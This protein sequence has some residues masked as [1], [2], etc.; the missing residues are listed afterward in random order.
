MEAVGPQVRHYGDPR[1]IATARWVALFYCITIHDGIAATGAR[2]AALSELSEALVNLGREGEE[3]GSPGVQPGTPSITSDLNIIHDAR[4]TLS[5]PSAIRMNRYPVRID[6][7]VSRLIVII[8]GKY[9]CEHDAD[10]RLLFYFR[11]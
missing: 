10:E 8:S 3:R 9:S 2:R 5:V 11:K 7:F 4:F 6:F 1:Q